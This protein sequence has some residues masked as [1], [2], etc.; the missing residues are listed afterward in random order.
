MDHLTVSITQE[1]NPHSLRIYF[2][3]MRWLMNTKQKTVHTLWVKR[4]HGARYG[5]YHE[6]P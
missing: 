5:W 4:A 2:F 6:L 3:A 1:L